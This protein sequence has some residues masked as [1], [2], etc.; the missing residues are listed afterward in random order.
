MSHGYHIPVRGTGRTVGPGRY[1]P[2]IKYKIKGVVSFSG[3]PRSKDFPP[4]PRHHQPPLH[5]FNHVPTPQ[6]QP[7]PKKNYN[8]KTIHESISRLSTPKKVYPNLNRNTSM[9]S[10][11]NPRCSSPNKQPQSEGK[12]QSRCAFQSKKN[13]PNESTSI[14][15]DV[16]DSG[17]DLSLNTFVSPTIY[18]RLN[19]SNIHH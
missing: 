17:S 7:H 18:D 12:S 1:N 6:P 11:I 4:T 19:I 9:E 15:T 10:H 8:R 13:L 14:F 5:S 2:D 3:V 16:G